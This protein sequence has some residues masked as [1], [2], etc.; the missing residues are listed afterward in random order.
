M[1]YVQGAS[2]T[3]EYP[4]GDGSAGLDESTNTIAVCLKERGE[5]LIR[6]TKSTETGRIA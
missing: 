1:A 4:M 2:G 6:D 3:L 5:E